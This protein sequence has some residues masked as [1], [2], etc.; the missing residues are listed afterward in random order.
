VSDDLPVA[1]SGR[2]VREGGLALLCDIGGQQVWVPRSQLL[3]GTTVR[4]AG[5]DGQIVIPSWLA[6]NLQ[7]LT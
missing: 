2:L 7:L 5:D 3:V 4:H 1:F 6:R